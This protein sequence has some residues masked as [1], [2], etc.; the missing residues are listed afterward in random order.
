MNVLKNHFFSLIIML[1]VG[2]ICVPLSAQTTKE[3]LLQDARFSILAQALTK[4]E[5]MEVFAD[6]KSITLFAPTNA[7]FEDFL[8]RMSVESIDDLSVAQLKPILM[9]HAI[10][11]KIPSEGLYPGTIETLNKN[12]GLN[13]KVEKDEIILNND[14]GISFKDIKTSNGLIHG[15]NKVMIPH[16]RS[17]K[18][19]GSGHC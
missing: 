11:H 7:A 1:F 13:V 12:A 16:I 4:A 2:G 3:V 19:S 15:I 17:N 8:E 14:T 6:Q 9:F 5:L 10:A 18:E